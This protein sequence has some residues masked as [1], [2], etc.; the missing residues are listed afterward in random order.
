MEA[1]SEVT[2]EGQGEKVASPRRRRRLVAALFAV[3]G[4]SAIVAGLMADPG[5]DRG[6][7]G[8][9]RTAGST[10]DATTG[11]SA[12]E[13]KPPST[14][15]GG[16]GMEPEKTGLPAIP[17]TG[18]KVRTGSEDEGC[19]DTVAEYLEEWH[20]TNEEPEPCFTSQPP[21]NQEQPDGVPRSYNGERF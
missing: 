11:D 19:F 1:A 14:E 13:P 5:A 17:P 16:V 12:P 8:A 10:S 15:P 20:R 3:M 6:A 21:N 18:G 2:G 7:P 9:A 4:I